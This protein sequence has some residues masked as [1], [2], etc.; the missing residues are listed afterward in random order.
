MMMVKRH[1][2]LFML[3]VIIPVIVSKSIASPWPRWNQKGPYDGENEE[4]PVWKPQTDPRVPWRPLIHRPTGRPWWKQWRAEKEGDGDRVDTPFV[5]PLPGT[6]F[7]RETDW[8]SRDIASDKEAEIDEPQRYPIER[9]S[10]QQ[11]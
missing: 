11:A 5:H 7:K 2:R 1:A 10:D 4:K 8:Y 9:E 3:A 6:Y